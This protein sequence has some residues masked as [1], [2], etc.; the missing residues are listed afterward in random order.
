M[1]M[2]DAN[3]HWRGVVDAGATVS[4]SAFLRLASPA[5]FALVDSGALDVW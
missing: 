4:M 1:Y 3:C 2:D 5:T